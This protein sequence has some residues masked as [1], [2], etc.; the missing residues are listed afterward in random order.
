MK[1]LVK[2]G[3]VVVPIYELGSGRYSV[4]YR[5]RGKR[6][7]KR[8]NSLSKAKA[9]AEQAAFRI[10]RGQEAAFSGFRRVGIDEIVEEFLEYKATLKLSPKYLRSLAGDLRPFARAFS[11][12]L[13]E[14]D[15][16]AISK[17]LGGLNVSDRRRNNVR[18]EIVTLWLF[19]KKHTFLRSD[20]KSFLIRFC[21]SGSIG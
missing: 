15:A 6:I 7:E 11:C 17:Y 5:E 8:Y 20:F 19:A 4:I 14:I 12:W 10:L 13:D 16:L 21:R 9:I 3:N 2:I 1:R 18:D